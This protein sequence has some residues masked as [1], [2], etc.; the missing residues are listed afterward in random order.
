MPQVNAM[1][2]SSGYVLLTFKVHEE[3]GLYVSECEELDVASFGETIEETFNSL[4][5]AVT[6][7]LSALEDEGERERVFAE[8]GIMIIPGQPEPDGEAVTILARPR[9]DV[10]PHPMPI[11]IGVK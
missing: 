3:D 4:E 6:V 10:S 7:Y 9:E 2:R 1:S 5:D 8:R 11:P